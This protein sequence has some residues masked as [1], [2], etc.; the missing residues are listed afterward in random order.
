MVVVDPLSQP[1]RGLTAEAT[2]VR[3]K[4]SEPGQSNLTWSPSEHLAKAVRLPI[5]RW[6]LDPI[7][8]QGCVTSPRLIAQI[9][10]AAPLADYAS[11]LLVEPRHAPWVASQRSGD[12]GRPARTRDRSPLRRKLIDVS[13]AACRSAFDLPD[14]PESDLPLVSRCPG[15]ARSGQLSWC[16]SL[17]ECGSWRDDDHRRGRCHETT[18]GRA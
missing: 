8:D 4:S 11:N 18:R 14:L 12:C 1:L 16:V 17:V 13:C 5:A 10:A 7:L 2:I 6:T 15:A 9:D 3:T